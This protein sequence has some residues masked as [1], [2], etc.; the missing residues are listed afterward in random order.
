MSHSLFPTNIFDQTML[1]LLM[2]S[3]NI[4]Y[5]LIIL[6]I[7]PERQTGDWVLGHDHGHDSKNSP[8]KSTCTSQTYIQGKSNFI[9]MFSYTQFDRITVNSDLGKIHMG[10]ETSQGS[11]LKML[12][13]T[14]HLC[15]IT[16]VLIKGNPEGLRKSRRNLARSR[17]KQKLN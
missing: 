11:N 6:L 8:F 17:V 9:V 3:T 2:H 12:P 5:S 15:I 1:I 10:F 13:P 14:N 4:Y 7:S 16:C